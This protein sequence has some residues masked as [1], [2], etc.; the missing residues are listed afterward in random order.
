MQVLNK[1][2]KEQLV[3]KLHQEGKTMPEIASAAHMSFGDIGKI[4]K[5]VDGRANDENDI[6][7]DNKSK[8]TKA[9]WLFENG[10]RP[11]DVAIGLDIPYDEVTDLQQE[12]W[13]LNQLYE[14]PLAYQELINDFD[15]F[16][17]LFR[18]LKENKMLSK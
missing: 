6:D 13:A 8:E 2:D 11:I 14:L 9:L 3:I 1:Y 5:K 15:S 4:I 10:K 12:Y 17:E 7:L 18:L 16:F